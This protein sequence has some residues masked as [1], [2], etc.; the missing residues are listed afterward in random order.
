MANPN[1]LRQVSPE[2]LRPAEAP[3]RLVSVEPVD[4]TARQAYQVLKFG[5]TIL[6]LITGFDKFNHILVNWD[7]Y[8]APLVPR[9]TG[10]AGHTFMLV[11]GVVEIIAGIGIAVKPK[12]FGYIVGLWLLGIVTNLLIVGY[13]DIA[14]RDFI[15]ALSAFALAR[16]ATGF[17]RR[18]T[19]IT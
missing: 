4:R 16:L 17:D 6:P 19:G 12:I 2:E 14:L 1:P 13:Y 3:T 11:G 5:F 8:L 10:I 7:Q 9:L 18:K 15:L